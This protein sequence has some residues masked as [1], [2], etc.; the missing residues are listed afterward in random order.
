MKALGVTFLA[1][2]NIECITNI[3]RYSD[4]YWRCKARYYS[5]TLFHP[6]GT[7]KMGPSTDPMAVVDAKLLVYGIVNLRVVDASI[8]PT[9]VSGNTNIPTIMIAERAADFIKQKYN[10]TSC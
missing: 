9:I 4:D 6:A 7:C 3:T 10:L 2:D 8:M 1:T 5:Q